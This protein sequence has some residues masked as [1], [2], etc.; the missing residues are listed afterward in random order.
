MNEQIKE[1]CTECSLCQKECT[2]LQ[3]YGNPKYIADKYCPADGKDQ[4]IAFECSLCG[5]CAAV[6]PAEIDPSRMFLEM[7][8]EAVSLGRGNFQEHKALL[9]YEKR[10]ISKRYTWYGL[11]RGC[12]TVLFPGCALPGTRPETVLNLFEHL[13]QSNPNLGIVLD[14]CTK[15][16]LDLGRQG[17]FQT[18][19][20]EM[21]A[22]L[23]DQG[24]RNVWVACPNCYRVFKEYGDELKVKTVYEILAENGLLGKENVSSDIT[25][26]D[27][28]VVRF[29]API[30]D[31]VRGLVERKGLAIQEMSHNR[32]TTLCCG[33]GGAIGL[34]SP[35]L[36]K[37]WAALRMKEA[38]GRRMI[39]YCAGCVNHLNPISPTSHL[40]DLLF[41]PQATLAGKIKSSRSPMTYWNRIRLKH[42]FK[43]NINA[44]VSRERIIS[45]RD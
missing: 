20:G 36:A 13:R 2:F 10:G 41:Q 44:P 29:E 17:Y 6:C 38:Q 7:R 15:P 1:K 32:H 21:T 4:G 16:S 18:L 3:K 43:K 25:I 5:L 42:W 22:Y 26:H 31:A 24:V 34:L 27:P 23:L 28:C 35:D 39:T 19:F 14:C 9:N 45:L 8:R 37:T 11:P 12:D 30:Q 40:L 33:E